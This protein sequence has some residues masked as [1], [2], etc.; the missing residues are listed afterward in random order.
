[1]R[2]NDAGQ[3]NGVF[4]LWINGTLEAN[5]SGLNW[6]GAYSAFGINAVFF[7]N[8]WNDGAPVEQTR[9]WDNIVVSTERI[10]C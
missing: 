5:R 8:Y 9:Y 2:L 4:D 1:M 6:V 3:S 7:E 10:G